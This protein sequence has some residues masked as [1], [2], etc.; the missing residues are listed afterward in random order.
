MQR[1][2]AGFLK[3]EQKENK[4]RLDHILFEVL[5]INSSE[6]VLWTFG[7]PAKSERDLGW[8]CRHRKT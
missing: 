7:I 2:G 8:R 5:V 1:G 6:D 3:E 4:L